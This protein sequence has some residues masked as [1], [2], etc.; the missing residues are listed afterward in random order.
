MSGRGDSSGSGRVRGG[1]RKGARGGACGGAHGGARDSP[2]ITQS[3]QDTFFDDDM[4]Q[5]EYDSEVVPETQQ[6][7]VVVEP[8]VFWMTPGELWFDHSSLARHITSV[9]QKYY[10]SPWTCYTQVDNHTKEHWFNLF[11]RT[12]KWPPEY[13]NLALH[14]YHEKA[15]QRL[16]DTHN[17]ITSRSGGKRPDWL[18]EEVHKEMMRHATEDPEFLKNSERS[19]KNR[20][21][22]S[23]TNSIEPTHF[24]GSIST[25]EHAKK[26]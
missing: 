17:Y 9:I 20:R 16:K 18:P 4:N 3:T 5:G 10:K 12:H 7:E 25:V 11:K 23:L 13:D 15:G 2:H 19:K 14:D 8:G 6:D 21:G 22:G 24:Q 1:G 26:W